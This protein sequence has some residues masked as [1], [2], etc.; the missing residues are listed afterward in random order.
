NRINQVGQNAIGYFPLPNTGAPG[1][2]FNNYF[3]ASTATNNNDHWDSRLDQDFTDKWH[4]F[5]RFSHDWNDNHPI[6]DY[7]NPAS[8]GGDGPATGGAWSVSMDHTLTLN[9]TLVADFRYGLSM[10][11]VTREAYGQGFDPTTLGFPQSLADVAAQRVLLFPRFDIQNTAGLGNN[12]Y[13][14]LIENPLSHDF[15]GNLT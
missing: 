8:A 7:G 1:A 5:V 6:D 11:Y 3:V 15:I 13:V 2:Q 4:M 9:P 10:S 12:G 14:P